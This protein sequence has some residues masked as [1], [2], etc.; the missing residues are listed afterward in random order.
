V[1]AT[2]DTFLNSTLD[3]GE[4]L[5]HAPEALNPQAEP[6]VSIGYEQIRSSEMSEV[7]MNLEDTK[8]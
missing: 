5:A 6:L 8:E 2:F 4:W 7:S 1:Q 3:K